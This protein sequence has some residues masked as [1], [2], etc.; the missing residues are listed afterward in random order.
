M[1]NLWRFRLEF[2]SKFT[3]TLALSLKGEGTTTADNYLRAGYSV[4]VPLVLGTCPALRGSSY[5][6][7]VL[8]DLA[9]LLKMASALW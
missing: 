1:W 3:L 8:S 6:R 4:M 7:A 5:S 9:R 2:G